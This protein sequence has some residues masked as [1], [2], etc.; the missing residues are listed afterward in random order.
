MA[1]I[2]ATMSSLQDESCHTATKIALLSTHD[3]QERAENLQDK[4]K[5]RKLTQHVINRDQG[6]CEPGY[7][8]LLALSDAR[9]GDRPL[10]KGRARKESPKL[11]PGD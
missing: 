6:T 2:F 10:S 4:G 11:K 9:R 8:V 1:P 7:G 3:L 5:D